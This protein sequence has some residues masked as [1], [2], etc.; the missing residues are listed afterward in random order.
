M[1]RLKNLLLCGAILSAL[2]LSA[3]RADDSQS[4]PSP[5]QKADASPKPEKESADAKEAPPKETIGTA[6]IA[7]ASLAYH[8]KTGMMP[9]LKDDGGV[10]ANLFY[11]YYKLDS[12]GDA[13][14]RPITFCFNGGPGSSSV[15][16]H[17]GAFGPKK[18]QLPSGTEASSPAAKIVDNPNSILDATDLVFIDPIATGL[19]RAAKGEKQEQFFDVDEDIKA[20]GEFI[21]LFVTRENRWL[22]PKYLCGESYGGL[23]VGG[24]VPYLQDE[25][26]MNIDGVI[27]LSGLLDFETL[28]EDGS[29]ELPFVLSLPA[30]AATASYYH[31]LA[32]DLQADLPKA[33][34]EAREFAH[35][36]YATALLKGNAI[37]PGEKQRVAEQLSRFTGLAARDISDTNLRITPDIFRSLLLRQEGK[38]LGRFD[39]RI[40]A[41]S[42][43]KLHNWP[44]FDPSLSAVLPIFS[45]GV[46]DYVR[47]N[48][49]YK[50]DAPYHVLGALPWHYGQFSNRY[51]S[52]TEKLGGALRQDPHMRLLVLLGKYDLAIPGDEMRY[53]IDHLPIP[54]SLRGNVTFASYDSG[55][56]MYLNPP[57]AAKLRA[58]LLAFYHGTKP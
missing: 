20:A 54:D 17:L 41:D 21:R 47:D 36:A 55:H 11:V 28:Y 38:I 29:N 37:D 16:L 57:D 1:S 12:G 46:N 31:K 34:R 44:E 13:A 18:V 2:M 9:I 56:M 8:V 7:G 19:S 6:Q 5:A 52:M 39:A 22:S 24:L 53:S 27:V 50:S 10:R 15:W 45:A 23:R 58:D 26:G 33:L 42:R 51:A 14:K 40:T 25:H 35:G 43:E 49:G 4:S 3:A 48:L 30:F 32:P